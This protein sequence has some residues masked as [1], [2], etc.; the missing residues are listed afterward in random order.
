MRGL[1]IGFFYDSYLNYAL[2]YSVNGIMTVS[3]EL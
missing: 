1:M 2:V 3:S